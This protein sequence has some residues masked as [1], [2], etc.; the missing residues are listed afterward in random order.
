MQAQ[1]DK[2]AQYEI[3]RPRAI[4]LET[5]DC[6]L[7]YS[8]YTKTEPPVF[9]R[10][11]KEEERYEYGQGEHVPPL[12]MRDDKNKYKKHDLTPAQRSFNPRLYIECSNLYCIRIVPRSAG[13][14]SCDSHEKER[15]QRISKD[16]FWLSYGAFKTSHPN[17]CALF[18]SH[19]S[20]HAT[21]ASACCCRA[22]RDETC[23]EESL[24]D[25]LRVMGTD[26][27][28]NECAFARPCYRCGLTP[29]ELKE[30]CPGTHGVARSCHGVDLVDPDSEV[31]MS[32]LRCCCFFCNGFKCRRS[33]EE[34]D[35]HAAIAGKAAEE[36]IN[37]RNAARLASEE[38]GEGGGGEG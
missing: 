22:C 18:H 4:E 8:E 14:R 15:N 24:W 32:N 19:V 21:D 23:T 3:D 12:H 26:E 30:L 9:L 7:A 34:A 11:L 16:D 25:L 31:T 20:A 5:A 29:E 17:W 36:R 35:E 2:L 6:T 1:I 27:D 13:Q 33:C 28:G 37:I 10:L 38:A